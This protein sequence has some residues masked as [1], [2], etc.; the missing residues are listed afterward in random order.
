[1]D[2]MEQVD[3]SLGDGVADDTH[4]ALA[5]K[6]QNWPIETDIIFA[7]G[8]NKV[9]LTAQDS[10]IQ[11]VIQ[12]AINNLRISLLF[13]NAFPTAVALP[14]IIEQSLFTATEHSGARTIREWLLYDKEYRLKMM[15]LVS[16]DI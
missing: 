5:S 6:S 16:C 12:D 14:A 13:E 8:S 10:V 3:A 1:V 15:R 4:D 2:P 11:V 9:T 7:K